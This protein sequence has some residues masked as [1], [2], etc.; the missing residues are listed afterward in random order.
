MIQGLGSSTSHMANGKNIISVSFFA[1]LGDDGRGGGEAGPGEGS[2]GV[3]SPGGHSRGGVDDVPHDGLGQVGLGNG[4]GDGDGLLDVLGLLDG[5]LGSDVGVLRRGV[6]DLAQEGSAQ[7]EVERGSRGG[8]Q[9][10]EN[11][12]LSS[13]TN[14][15][16]NKKK[17]QR[18]EKRN[19]R[20]CT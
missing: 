10:G 13:I 3:A 14:V 17:D 7:A 20:A 11:D 2:A 12:D 4:D 9:D 8:S 15:R 1:N 18:I 19:L 6:G 5:H 16:I